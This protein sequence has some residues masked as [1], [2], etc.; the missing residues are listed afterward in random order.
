MANA[1]RNVAPK[2]L[3]Y[4]LNELSTFLSNAVKQKSKP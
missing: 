2:K 1:N 4:A 3:E